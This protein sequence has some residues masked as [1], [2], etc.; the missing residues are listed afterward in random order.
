[1]EHGQQTSVARRPT[2]RTFLV[3]GRVSNLPTVWSNCLAGWLLAGGEGWFTFLA[4]CGSGTLLYI[5]GMY[6]NDVFDADF[7]RTWRKER[8]IPAGAISSRFA[9]YVGAGCLAS[10]FLLSWAG[11]RT[12]G[13][14]A[15]LLAANIILYDA[16]HK[17][18]ALS[19]VLMA[20]CR[21]W[22]YTL[23]AAFAG[24][25]TGIAVWSAIVCAAYVA[26]ISYAAKKESESGPLRYWPC[27][28]LFAPLVLAFLSNEGTSHRTRAAIFSFI[29]AAW[30]AIAIKDWL[31]R[32]SNGVGA[33]VSKL[34]A[35]LVLVDLLAVNDWRH[36]VTFAALFATA[37][38]FQRRI[39][40]T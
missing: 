35:G 1:M 29:L 28:L 36:L 5:G 33:G 25:V 14:I 13:A 24:T 37:L 26:G 30:I 23:A 4:L 3:L 20:G 11:G 39:P 8:P 10:G 19:P 31:S 16:V 32:A 12:A 27:I 22:L 6:L 2:L 9:L 40:A 18:T 17:H 34:L 21:L 15:G 38:L 7:D